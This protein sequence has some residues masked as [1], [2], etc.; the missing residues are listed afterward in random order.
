MVGLDPSRF[1]R[2]FKLFTWWFLGERPRFGSKKMVVKQDGKWSSQ[3]WDFGIFPSFSDFSC[4][5]DT[6]S[7]ESLSIGIIFSTVEE[8]RGHLTTFLTA[9]ESKERFVW[10]WTPTNWWL[11]LFPLE[12]YLFWRLD[13]IFRHTHVSYQVGHVPYYIYTYIS[14]QLYPVISPFWR[15]CCPHCWWQITHDFL[16]FATKIPWNPRPDWGGLGRC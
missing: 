5:G 16:I 8:W 14:I 2:S 11:A 3:P 12:W 9:K 15:V 6:T 10:K 13:C 4:G 7:V 1:L